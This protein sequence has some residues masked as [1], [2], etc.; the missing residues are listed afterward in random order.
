MENFIESLAAYTLISYIFGG[1]YHFSDLIYL[2]PNGKLYPHEIWYILGFSKN[3]KKLTGE[4]SVKDWGVVGVD[5]VD[6]FLSSELAKVINLGSQRDEFADRIWKGFSILR[7]NYESVL[8][9]FEM[10]LGDWDPSCQY[11]SKS[12]LSKQLGLLHKRL[13][14]HKTEAE[15]KQKFVVLCKFGAK[16]NLVPSNED[17]QYNEY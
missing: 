8:H 2:L 17:E 7:K 11:N 6:L 15:I 1:F 4:N 3:G 14:V 12:F 5:V 10:I 16:Q 9:I 13:M